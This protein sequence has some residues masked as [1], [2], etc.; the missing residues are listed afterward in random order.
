[1]KKSFKSG[2]SILLVEDDPLVA[3]CFTNIIESLSYDCIRVGNIAQAWS[4]CKARRF[5]MV[6]CDHDLPDGKGIVLVEMMLRTRMTTP[7][8][9]VSA[10]APTVLDVLRTYPNVKDVLSKPTEKETLAAAISSPME[11]PADSEFWLFRIASLT[12]ESLLETSF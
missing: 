5:A 11:K 12:S 7:V 3:I 9:Y 6:V 4:A 8:L 1:M 2:K 10:A